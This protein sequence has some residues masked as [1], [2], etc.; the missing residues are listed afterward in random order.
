MSGG[1]SQLPVDELQADVSNNDV[2]PDVLTAAHSLY[3]SEHGRRASSDAEA[4]A[5]VQ[6]M[7]ARKRREEA[8]QSAASCAT[9]VPPNVLAAASS[10]FIAHHGR[11]A[12]STGEALAFAQQLA[13]NPPQNCQAAPARMS[14]CAASSSLPQSNGAGGSG[15]GSSGDADDMLPDD[16]PPHVA[17]AAFAIFERHL[18]RPA[19]NA[20]EAIVFARRVVAAASD[21]SS[22]PATC[23]TSASCDE[24]G[25]AP[26]PRQ[27]RIEPFSADA[28]MVATEATDAE[29]EAEDGASVPLVSPRGATRDTGREGLCFRILHRIESWSEIFCF[30]CTAARVLDYSQSTS[31]ATL[32]RQ[33]VASVVTSESSQ[34]VKHDCEQ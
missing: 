11:P 9:G 12:A 5:Y 4:L 16:V 17:A 21:A 20:V 34:H 24:Q 27:S 18:G 10:L 25:E 31:S 7:V 30:C 22:Q 1:Y 8:S 6:Q 19:A 2:P 15:A 29:S 32:A 26:R 23:A 3:R 33:V 14:D 13:A 28:D